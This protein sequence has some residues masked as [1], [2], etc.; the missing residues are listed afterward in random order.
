[1]GPS[2]TC[3]PASSTT[4]PSGISLSGRREIR[5]KYAKKKTLFIPNQLNL[6]NLPQGPPVLI[7]NGVDHGERGAAHDK[8][9]LRWRQGG[10][11][12]GGQGEVHCTPLHCIILHCS[13]LHS[14]ALHCTSLH[15]TAPSCRYYT[16]SG[17]ASGVAL[18]DTW[19]VPPCFE[20]RTTPGLAGLEGREEL[21]VAEEWS[22]TEQRT[23]SSQEYTAFNNIVDNR[24]WSSSNPNFIKHQ[25]PMLNCLRNSK[26]EIF[27]YR[28]KNI[29]TRVL[30]RYCPAESQSQP[31]GL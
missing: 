21:G 1:M 17:V 9:H 25:C 16:C 4:S 13:A 31:S 18:G 28:R 24:D 19:P 11:G 26:K 14:T 20:D 10:G 12:P 29:E 22:F 7:W 23:Q 2:V 8:H 15:C 30:V 5:E 3:R 6:S 27:E